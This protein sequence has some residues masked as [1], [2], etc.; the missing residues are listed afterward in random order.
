MP[1]DRR[2]VD[3]HHAGVE[4]Q[5]GVFEKVKLQGD[6]SREFAVGGEN[7]PA[8]HASEA[9]EPLLPS[10]SARHSDRG[11][12]VPAEGGLR[13]A[14]SVH[15]VEAIPTRFLGPALDP[16]LIKMQVATVVVAR[17]QPDLEFRPVLAMLPEHVAERGLTR[18]GAMPKI[19]ED[20]ELGR[21]GLGEVGGQRLEG[22]F[23]TARG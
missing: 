1:K 3:A 12:Q 11:V 2:Q 15:E 17:H 10:W 18:L 20:D 22:G 4:A 5:N 6:S 8:V 13:I 7:P 21:F 19:A 16:E 23:G 14:G 9:P